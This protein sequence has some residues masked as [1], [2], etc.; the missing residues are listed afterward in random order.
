MK[1]MN[2]R[3]RRSK[4]AP[5]NKQR[6]FGI[7]DML[8]GVAIFAV[9]IGAIF[10]IMTVVQNSNK[11]INQGRAATQL[12]TEI[13]KLYDQNYTTLTTT[14]INTGKLAPKPFTAPTGTTLQHAWGGAV[15]V[16]PGNQAG[17][18]PITQFKLTF[19]GIPQDTCLD[20]VKQLS[21]ASYSLWVG[22]TTAGTHDVVPAGTGTFDQSKAIT[23]CAALAATGNIILVTQ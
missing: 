1:T 2:V 17:A 4:A 5:R 20:F 9:V 8:I 7:M 16:G 14:L 12:I 11:A 22:G 19:T 13:Q 6:G 21:G 15:V 10:A 23:Q 3:H 18:T